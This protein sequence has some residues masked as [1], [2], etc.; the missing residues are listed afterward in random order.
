[1]RLHLLL[2]GVLLALAGALRPA[3]GQGQLIPGNRTLAGTLNAGPSTGT[4]TA[5]LL[6]L[7]PPTPAYVVDQMFV[8]RAHTAN[9]GPATL[10]V[11]GR[12]ALP[13]KKWQAGALVG[14][15]AGEIPR[16]RATVGM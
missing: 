15:A 2:L 6:A 1:M 14:L 13:L 9:T 11:D 16:S 8:F 12:G 4:G 7:N 10:N 3:W 5:Y